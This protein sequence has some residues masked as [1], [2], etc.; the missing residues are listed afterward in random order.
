[1]IETSLET[2]RNVAT[3]E[4]LS[5]TQMCEVFRESIKIDDVVVIMVLEV[6]SGY[7]SRVGHPVL[8]DQ[9]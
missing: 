3:A 5:T 1:M 2:D 8:M 4:L 9:S 7:Q 6:Q